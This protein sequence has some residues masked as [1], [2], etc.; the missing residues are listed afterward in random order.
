MD[1]EKLHNDAELWNSLEKVHMKDRIATCASQ[2]YYTIEGRTFNV[3][4]K[5]LLYLARA[6][7]SQN[8]V[9]AINK[10]CISSS[11][12]NKFIYFQQIL[13]LEECD[14]PESLRGLVHQVIEKEFSETT[15]LIMTRRLRTV[16]SCD[17][18]LVMEDNQV[19]EFDKPSTLLSDPDSNLKKAMVKMQEMSR[20]M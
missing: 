17:R 16:L 19:L 13:S 11:H 6:F 4:E 1:P 5:Q 10:I 8:K 20:R 18:V 2:L 3:I 15:V 14:A 9:S 12:S 7:L